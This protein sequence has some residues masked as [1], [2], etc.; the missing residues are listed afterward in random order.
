MV[1]AWE[2]PFSR[3]TIFTFIDPVTKVEREFLIDA[4]I[5]IGTDLKGSLT[6]YPV[7]G[8]GTINDHFQASPL[9]LNIDGVIA[10]SPSQQTLTIAT[11]LAER[12]FLST[13]S[14]KGLSATFITL[15]LSNLAAL[16]V[17]NIGKSE[18]EANFVALLTTRSEVDVDYPK[19]AM[20]GLTKA[21]EQGVKFNIRTFFSDAVYQDMIITSLNFSQ[22]DKIGDS[23]SFKMT[24]EKLVTVQAFKKRKG[25]LQ[26]ADPANGSAT[27]AVDKG[28][29][30]T[31]EEKKK[32][33]LK[34]IVEALTDALG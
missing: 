1:A 15:A 18:V 25:E 23:L 13:G 22:T 7:E 10:E 29:K 16:S 24:L 6:R 8:G 31:E 2:N 33:M 14:F 4:S 3:A 27:D 20:L 34:K 19:R 5:S 28:K 21:F 17:S 11:S 12:A 32:T 9:R 30:A 26:V